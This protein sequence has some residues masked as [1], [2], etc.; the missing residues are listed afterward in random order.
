MNQ[1]ENRRPRLWLRLLLVILVL[2][3]IAGPLGYIKKNQIDEMSTQGSQVPPPISVT[4]A[5]AKNAQW[6]RRIKAIGTLVAF[7]DVAVTTEVSG[8]VTS[9]NFDSGDQVKASSLMVEFDAR[10]E[11]ANLKSAEAQFEADNSQ[12]QRLLK[13]KDQSFVT[14]SDIDVQA[15]LVNISAATVNVAKAALSKKQIFAPF[16]GKL[17]IR[18]INLGQFVSPGESIVTL[19]SFDKLY[20]DFSLPEQNFR[21]LLVDQTI[22]FRVRA[23]P[24]ETFTARVETWNPELNANT[25]NISVRAVV[26]NKGQLLAPGMFADME[27]SS[28]LKVAV[29]TIPETAIFYNIYGEAVYVLEQ[30]ENSEDSS[31]P[32]FRLA[33]RKVDVAYRQSGVAGVRSGLNDGD[34]VVTAGQ[35]KLYPSL[36]V[37]IVDDVPEYNTS[38][39]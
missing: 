3:A 23:F 8:V 1:P 25:R 21:D 10:T 4:V 15:S 34:V 38:E 14:K 13:L 29:N 36:R 22:K 32:D 37:A 33:A 6:Q 20:L 35:L 7:K 18:K 2:G 39:Q 26:Q 31:E 17:G 16:S 27:I 19:L 24:N 28:R 12:Y 30:Q 11:V 9:I 5:T